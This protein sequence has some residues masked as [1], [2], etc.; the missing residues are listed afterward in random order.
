MSKEETSSEFCK[1]HSGFDSR[2][3]AL[4]HD[5]G[6]QWD[7]IDKLRNRPPV[8]ASAIISI[9][10]FALGASLTYAALVIRLAQVV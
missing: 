10:M 8:W 9:L 7:A 3:E 5:R 2:I 4:E 1:G 6:E